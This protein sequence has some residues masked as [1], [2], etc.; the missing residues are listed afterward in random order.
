MNLQNLRIESLCQ[1]FKVDTF[2]T[3]WPVLAQQ[4]AKKTS[5]ADF[6]EK[7]LLSEDRTRN[8]RRRQALPQHSAP[9]A[10]KTVEQ[11]DFKF[12]SGAP[13]SQTLELPGLAFISARKTSCCWEPS[14]VGKT[15]LP[16][17]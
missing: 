5:H 10:L 11:W 8:E 14:G 7:L 2:A 9:P 15:H 1:Q 6:L 4:A 17:G 13:Q 16:I 3:N 12:A